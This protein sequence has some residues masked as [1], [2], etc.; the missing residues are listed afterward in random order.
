MKRNPQKKLAVINDLSGYGRCSLSVILPIV[1]AMKIQCCPVVTSI[2]SNHT[3]YSHC[4]KEDFT[5]Q[6]PEYIS[7]WKQIGMEFDGILTGY[8]GSKEQIDIVIDFITSFAKDTLIVVDPVMGD[9]GKRYQSF[10]EEHCEKMKELVKKAHILTPNITEACILTNTPYKTNWS[11][12]EIEEICKKLQTFGVKII[13]ITGVFVAG[14]FY[15]YI[16]DGEAPITVIKEEK[17]GENRPG[18]G[19]IF[20]SIVMGSVM[21]HQT[22]ISGV[23]KASHFVK[24]CIEQ[25]ERWNIPIEDGVCFEEFLYTL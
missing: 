12:K 16:K 3:G 10:T 25:S 8:L 11:E 15:N 20:T 18:T 22:V 23:K 6:M 21:N 4:F 7:H 5:K 14:V 2:L 17:V 9:H 13:I 1:S 24:Q 19:D